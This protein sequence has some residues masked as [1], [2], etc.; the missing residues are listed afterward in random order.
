MANN[1]AIQ[2]LRGSRDYDP[3]EI[4]NELLDGQP[5]YSK[6]NEQ[7]Y[8]GDKSKVVE[9]DANGNPTSYITR[10]AGA[11]WIKPGEGNGS[12]ISACLEDE[13]G[14]EY[15]TSDLPNAGGHESIA[16]GKG[17]NAQGNR[18][19]IF[20]AM[21]KSSGQNNATFGSW[22]TNNCSNSIISG[23]QNTYIKGSNSIILR[24]END[25]G[26]HEGI[27]S[28]NN[29]ISGY[30]N[31]VIQ[32][33][34]IVNGEENY[35][36]ADNNIVSG[37]NNESIRNY[38]YLLG[39]NLQSTENDYKTAVGY[40]N[41]DL[42]NSLFEIGNGNS[43]SGKN[44]FSVNRD[45]DAFVQNRL[46][47]GRE[48]SGD[49]D[50]SLFVADE[51]G[52]CLLNLTPQYTILNPTQSGYQFSMHREVSSPEDDD[53]II[54]N[55]TQNFVIA[56]SGLL[57]DD[58]N[59]TNY[60][61]AEFGS[62]QGLEQV[63]LGYNV[64][65]TRLGYDKYTT[66]GNGTFRTFGIYSN[67]SNG[68][69]M[70]LGYWD[71]EKPIDNIYLTATDQ[72]NFN[73]SGSDK[74]NI[75]KTTVTSKVPFKSE[76]S[77]TSGG[78]V[79][80][81]ADLIL[82][83]ASQ[84][85]FRYLG[86]DNITEKHSKIYHSGGTIYT[87]SDNLIINSP[88]EIRGS[89][90][91]NTSP[92]YDTSVIRKKDLYI[93]GGIVPEYSYDRR[94]RLVWQHKSG[95]NELT[96]TKKDPNMTDVTNFKD[97]D[98]FL[99]PGIYKVMS[100][101]AAQQILN[102]PEPYAGVLEV[103]F[104]AKDLD[105]GYAW[106]YPIQDYMTVNGRTTYRRYSILKSGEGTFDSWGPWCKIGTMTALS[107]Y[108]DTKG[109]IESRLTNLGFKSGVCAIFKPDTYQLEEATVNKGASPEV[110]MYAPPGSI[111]QGTQY[112][113]I[114]KCGKFVI[115]H[116]ELV[117]TKLTN[118]PAETA[119]ARIPLDLAPKASDNGVTFLGT[120]S[121]LTNNE[122]PNFF[123][124]EYPSLFKIKSDGWIICQED[125]NY[126]TQQILVASGGGK[127]GSYQKYR[128]DYH[129]PRIVID[130]FWSI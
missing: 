47:V 128:T 52:A 19:V 77:I 82:T 35:I 32:S 60:R 26:Q 102:L 5:F 74:F 124:Y 126:T 87:N 76:S 68:K 40:Y 3:S 28:D 69:Y 8:V 112:N 51:N 27:T 114:R 4:N 20:G 78:S 111:L 56:R 110:N 98:S 64:T 70:Q 85:S 122:D 42:P 61:Y 12:F 44:A 57:A 79:S 46:T 1:K 121:A 63:S 22:N 99:Q 31:T 88:V 127:W 36:A 119:F 41:A 83:N 80:V 101:I 43:S 34:N 53:F 86:E 93:N 59:Q 11:S 24:S 115:F 29:I 125:I 73:L 13:D 10:P 66:I 123:A 67:A 54:K 65:T 81:G 104:G 7:L 120:R 17:N 18:S 49:P 62:G 58:R 113:Y 9:T 89:L 118:I 30:N 91:C 55:S 107:G 103:H 37:Y 33:Y 45:G 129:T 116:L 16:F 108:D 95:T 71:S 92:S 75:S 97:I 6:K 50:A 90:I 25:I 15:S 21:N 48:D 14:N 100:D 109:T 72:F 23:L 96:W 117:G 130:A 84:I 2:I 105:D 38:S 39:S 94:S 106:A